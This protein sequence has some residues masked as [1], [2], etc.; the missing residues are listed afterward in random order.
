MVAVTHRIA[1][2]ILNM[3]L[4]RILVILLA[5]QA[6]SGH[7][8]NTA[9]VF[10]LQADGS[11]GNTLSG[12]PALSSEN[13]VFLKKA[14]LWV[15]GY[16]QQNRLYVAA[17]CLPG[18][19]ASDFWPGPMDTLLIKATR[20]EDWNRTWTTT[21]REIA[22]HRR[23]WN[24]PAY[25]IPA[26]IN[27]WPGQGKENTAKVLAPFADSDF[28]GVYSP[29]NGDFPFI[30]GEMA[31]YAISNDEYDEHQVSKAAPLKLEVHSMVYR[32]FE[33]DS[34]IFLRYTLFNRT[35]VVLKNL[36]LSLV[37]EL[38]LG[39]PYDNGFF[40]DSS[41]NC[42]A[43]WNLD[44]LDEGLSGFGGQLPWMVISSLNK[45]LQ[46]TMLMTGENQRRYPATDEEFRN[47]QEGKLADGSRQ[48]YPN[49]VMS[50][51]AFEKSIWQ[52]TMTDLSKFSAIS[53]GVPELPPGG[54]T[55]WDIALCAGR[56]EGS[57]QPAALNTTP[58]YLRSMYAPFASEE[59]I[60]S[61]SGLSV[62]VDIFPVPIY[63]NA[64]IN[65]H[66]SEVIKSIR[67][68]DVLGK[69]ILEK[70]IQ[71]GP[72]YEVQT[73][74]HALQNTSESLLFIQVETPLGWVSKRVLIL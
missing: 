36:R 5:F 28:D 67:I 39:N 58:S 70:V 16:D 21:S 8:Q 1:L 41:Q 23:S 32:P 52:D 66:S 7:A 53:V 49:N 68:V 55:R 56:N 31:S 38:T 6:V 24:A 12:A 27:E 37:S 2:S 13:K 14:G 61:V 73:Q 65:I 17:H 3:Y 26:S 29:E 69:V 9:L 33:T 72:T 47:I 48:I 63:S 60:L 62:S 43:A 15:S 74:I 10:D 30:P 50:N 40:S 46:A 64:I 34:V 19:V 25:T 44:D 35:P 42:I 51:F 57:G 54:G 45:P 18:N 11:L 59:R 22:V 71:D 20:P 4:N